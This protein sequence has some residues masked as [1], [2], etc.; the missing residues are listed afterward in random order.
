[1]IFK[2]EG[3]KCSTLLFDVKVQSSHM[4]KNFSCTLW[5]WGS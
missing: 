2:V 5:I 4:V 3:D 1:M